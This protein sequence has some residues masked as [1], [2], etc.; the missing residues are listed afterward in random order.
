M[1][2]FDVVT[3][4][5]TIRE[6]TTRVAADNA[7]ISAPVTLPSFAGTCE[8]THRY[9]TPPVC[10]R[11]TM[12]ILI[13]CLSFFFTITVLIKVYFY[14][15]EI[16]AE[17]TLN[18]IEE[19]E[20]A[21]KEDWEHTLRVKRW[22][23]KGW[24]EYPKVQTEFLEFSTESPELSRREKWLAKKAEDRRIKRILFSNQILR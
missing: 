2:S 24:G 21:P 18:F 14:L 22:A 13:F 11:D 20:S 12:A 7:I 19:L 5:T 23:L 4:L 1:E 8:V 17:N 15:N 3:H 10:T 6:V 16:R 9:G